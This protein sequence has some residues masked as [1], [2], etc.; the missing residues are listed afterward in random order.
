MTGKE[1][2][3]GLDVGTSSMVAVVAR[4]AD[5]ERVAGVGWCPSLGMRKGIVIDLEGVAQAVRRAVEMAQ[6]ATGCRIGTVCVGFSG[7][8]VNVLTRHA[9]I[10]IG[11]GGKITTGDVA[12]LIQ[13]LRQVEVPAGR[14]VLQVVP[15]EFMI[16]GVP[17]RDNPVGRTGSKLSLEARVV[18]VDS[19]I[20]DQLVT[21]VEAAGLRVVEVV[22]NPLVVAQG[23]LSTV[24]R[25]LGAAL[26]DLGGGTTAVTVFKGGTL[27]D[28]TVIPVGGEHITSDLAIGVRTSLDAAEKVKREIGLLPQEA[29]FVE[30]PS[31]GGL[32]SRRASLATIRQ[33]IESR[34]LEIL[35]LIKQNIDRLARGKALPGG[36]ILAGGGSCLKGLPDL[37]SRVLQLPV[38]VATTEPDW[39]AARFLARHMAAWVARRENYRLAV[40]AGEFRFE[41]RGV[42]QIFAHLRRSY[43]HGSGTDG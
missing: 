9:D 27:V 13:I 32:A 28:M 34:V 4:V 3:A 10:T 41:P 5:P 38:R 23:V 36:V 14:R 26:V 21:A 24:E 29:V 12:D 15:V 16:D 37:A 31:M 35:D 33:I 25:E 18:T 8:G 6:E 19:Q 11:H 2:V 40:A 17:R 22:L 20:V 1:V 43:P 30:L 7:H 39:Q 42:R